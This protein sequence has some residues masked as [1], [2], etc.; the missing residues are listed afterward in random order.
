MISLDPPR[1]GF[2]PY[3]LAALIVLL[4]QVCKRIVL[5]RF[6]LGGGVDLAG[7]Y[8]RFTHLQNS[9]GA[10]GIFRDSPVPFA[11]LSMVAAITLVVVIGRQPAAARSE[12]VA[13]SL[14][15]G[16]AVGNL[17]D[18]IQ[19]GYVVDFIDIGFHNLR[20][21]VFNLA[22]MAV[23]TGVGLFLLLS[24]RRGDR[25]DHEQPGDEGGDQEDL[26]SP[27]G[28]GPED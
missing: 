4:D 10:F 9:G 3:A 16:G 5:V 6:D 2:N 19:F 23:V 12:R 17:I 14:I 25:I 26:H 13:L 1:K 11:L 24:M 8:I 22:D 20:W 21:P 27:G 7:H 18:R 15:L 28:G